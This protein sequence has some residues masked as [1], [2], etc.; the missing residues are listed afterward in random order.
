M[1]LRILMVAEK[2]SISQSIAEILSK[3]QVNILI[4]YLLIMYL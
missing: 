3:N 2:P 1:A 4:K